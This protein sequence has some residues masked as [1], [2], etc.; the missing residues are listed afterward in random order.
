MVDAILSGDEPN[1]LSVV[2]LLRAL[3]AGWEEQREQLARV[4]SRQRNAA[5]LQ[6]LLVHGSPPMSPATLQTKRHPPT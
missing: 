3:P 4:P 1:G 2:A 5:Q 6:R